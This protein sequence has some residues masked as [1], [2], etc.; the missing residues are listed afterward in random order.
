MASLELQRCRI[1][2]DLLP[3]ASGLMGMVAPQDSS[4]PDMS[5]FGRAL[6]TMSSTLGPSS[7]RSSGGFSM[8]GPRCQPSMT[9]SFCPVTSNA[10]PVTPDAPGLASQQPSG[11][12]WGGEGCAFDYEAA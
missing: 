7:E 8:V 9:E 1:G 6:A 4:W 5:A 2:S 12:R 11:A 3:T 10:R